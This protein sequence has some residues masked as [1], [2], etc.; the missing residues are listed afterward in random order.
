MVYGLY[1]VYGI[2]KRL[3]KSLFLHFLHMNIS[4]RR[5]IFVSL[6]RLKIKYVQQ[7]IDEYEVG[8]RVWRPLFSLWFASRLVVCDMSCSAS[9]NLN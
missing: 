1:L 8:G 7:S 5:N 2:S 3:S 9:Y 6:S 4:I